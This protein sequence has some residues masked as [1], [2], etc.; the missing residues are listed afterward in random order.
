MFPK[1]LVWGVTSGLYSV[2]FVLLSTVMLVKCFDYCH[3]VPYLKGR[4]YSVSRIV[5]FFFFRVILTIQV[6]GVSLWICFSTY[7]RCHWPGDQAK[8]N[9]ETDLENSQDFFLSSH[10]RGHWLVH[11]VLVHVCGDICW[12]YLVLGLLHF[13]LAKDLWRASAFWT[14]KSFP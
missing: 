10:C 12:C 8:T 2:P 7:Q 6:F 14:S 1:T 13:S 9:T 11:C 5:F 3:F 4:Q